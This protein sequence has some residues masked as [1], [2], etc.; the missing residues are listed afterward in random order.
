MRGS[1]SMKIDNF[2]KNSFERKIC[3]WWNVAVSWPFILFLKNF[4][5]HRGQ[6]CPHAR[7]QDVRCGL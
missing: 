6:V 7:F 4:W 1:A 3:A 2:V 5:R